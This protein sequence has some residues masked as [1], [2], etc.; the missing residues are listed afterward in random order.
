MFS[1]GSNRSVGYTRD[2][3]QQRGAQLEAPGG[4]LQKSRG[5]GLGRSLAE[6]S[7]Q[8]SVE[9]NE[10]IPRD[11]RKGPSD[12]LVLVTQDVGLDLGPQTFPGVVTLKLRKPQVPSLHSNLLWT[13][14]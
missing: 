9:E 6:G 12:R 7:G 5:L 10:S 14:M 1:L 13:G 3:P 8:V 11:P 2:P 4:D